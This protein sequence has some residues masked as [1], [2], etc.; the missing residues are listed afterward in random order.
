MCGALSIIVLQKKFFLYRPGRI[1]ACWSPCEFLRPYSKVMLLLLQRDVAFALEYHRR[2]GDV[3]AGGGGQYAY[4]ANVSVVPLF[5]Y[6][7]VLPLYWGRC[8]KKYLGHINVYDN[9]V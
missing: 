7:V 4:V 8:N 3:Y 5:Y 1:L 6:V 9:F 2:R